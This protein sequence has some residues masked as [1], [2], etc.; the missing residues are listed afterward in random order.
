MAGGIDLDLR[1]IAGGQR[2]VIE[3]VGDVGKN[4]DLAKVLHGNQR[5]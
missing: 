5:S 1:G 2:R 4:G 3:H